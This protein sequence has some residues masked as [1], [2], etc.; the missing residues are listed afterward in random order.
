MG[1]RGNKWMDNTDLVCSE[2]RELNWP[3]GEPKSNQICFQKAQ[4]LQHAI[5]L[6]AEVMMGLQ[7]GGWLAFH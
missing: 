4:E 7:K 5:T 1:K 3:S 6:E 2:N